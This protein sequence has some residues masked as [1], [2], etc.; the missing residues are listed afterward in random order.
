[1]S[2]QIDYVH[3]EIQF[4]VRHMMVTWGRGSFEKFEG[5]IN[6]DEEN[7]ENS[8]VEIRIEA[9]SVN[10]RNADRDAHLRSPDFFDAPNYPYITFKSKKVEQTGPNTAKLIGDLTIRDITKEVTVDVTYEGQRKSPFGPYL[11]AGFHAEAVIN[12]KEWGLN[13]NSLLE[14]GGVLVGDDVYITADIELNKALEPE[15]AAA[16]TA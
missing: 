12:R 3:S 11:A 15:A 7:P 6:L 9:A 4:K 8:T 5:T 2:W 14:G 16:T 1:M 10:T 13:W